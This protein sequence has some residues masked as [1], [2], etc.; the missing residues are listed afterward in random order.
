MRRLRA[1]IMA[2]GHGKRMKSDTSKVLHGVCGKAMID[3][4]LE[5]AELCG[6]E[7]TVIVV[8]H[9]AEEVMAHVGDRADYAFQHEL[10]GTAHAVMQT[11]S[12]FE[13]YSGDVLILSGDVPAITAETLKNCYQTHKNV[14]AA[15]TVLAARV[16]DPSGYGR[17][18][19][20]NGEFKAIVEHKDA[21]AEE[22][23]VK[24]I[25][26]GIYFFD[27]ALLFGALKK[28]SNDNAQG[29]Y[30]LPDALSVMKSEGSKI[31]VA[32][33]NDYTELLGVNDRFQLAEMNRLINKRNIK[34]I[35]D[36]GVT[37]TD[38]ENT[39]IGDDVTVGCDT[40]IEPGCFIFGKTVIGKACV[41][42]PQTRLT[43]MKVGS[44]VSVLNSV[45][46]ES[47]ISDGAN[48]GPF[49]YIR[50]GSKIGKNVKIGDF[51]EIKN[52][53]LGEGTKVSHLTYVGDSDVGSNVNFGC[54]T[55]TVNYD[56]NHKH[57]TKIGDNAFIGC[58]TNL[59]APV[60]VAENA[61]TAAGSTITDDVP[62]DSLA[63]ARAKQVNKYGW[64]TD[65]KEKN[66]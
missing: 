16:D 33:M 17:V 65:R 22:L 24:L 35:M 14:S 10:L 7:K 48:V 3:R 40:V 37:V 63:I 47:E 12:F 60:E 28:I 53:S 2:A 38:P 13:G 30:Y 43:D 62:A 54:G 41:I 42:G 45:C 61:F 31:A 29:E 1:V 18:I 59:V 46:T 57:R 25:N 39:Y 8:G 36:S 20:E 9:K 11:E 66:K 58:N 32:L 15:A 50:P 34:R 56:G 44:N 64:V 55:V 4:C 5:A 23:A 21:N 6:A 27:S 19:Q 49:A 26:S 51:V 52:S